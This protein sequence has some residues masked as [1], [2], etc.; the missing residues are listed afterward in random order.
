[1]ATADPTESD[2]VRGPDVPPR[3]DRFDPSPE[4]NPRPIRPSDTP[5]DADADRIDPLDTDDNEGFDEETF[6]DDDG[7]DD[8]A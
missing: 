5:E 1:M 7:P 4:G 8:A 3:E 2:P 6:D